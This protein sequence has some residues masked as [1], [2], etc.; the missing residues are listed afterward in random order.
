MVPPTFTITNSKQH[1]H[2]LIDWFEYLIVFKMRQFR[3]IAQLRGGRHRR[4]FFVVCSFISAFLASIMVKSS[5][6]V[7]AARGCHYNRTKPNNWLKEECFI[8]KP[9]TKSDCACPQWYHFHR[10]LKDKDAKM[11]WLKRPRLK[12]NTQSCT[13]MFIPLRGQEANT[14]KP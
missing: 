8:H 10:L 9:E 13:C 7:C 11:I 2:A 14:G 6:T 4:S 12:T 1:W 3:A 5:G